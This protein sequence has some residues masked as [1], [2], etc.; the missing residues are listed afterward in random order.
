MDAARLYEKGLSQAAI[1][2]EL[3]VSRQSVSRWCETLKEAGRTGLRKAGRAGRK[4]KLCA[5]DLRK[6]EQ[7]LKKGPEELG[8]STSLWTAAR[9]GKLIEE[10]SG[11]RFHVAHVWRILRQLGWSC[12]RPKSQ[13]LEKDEEKIRHWKRRRWPTL[14]KTLPRGGKP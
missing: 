9:V 1:A 7:R 5:R 11:V 10:I 4:S 2:K 12:Q 3:R 8:Y 14:K 6:L 13:A